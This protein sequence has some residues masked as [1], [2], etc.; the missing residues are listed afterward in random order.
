M[1]DQV[2]PRRGGGERRTCRPKA[3]AWPKGCCDS[4]TVEAAGWR[5]A[6][7][8]S[9]HTDHWDREQNPTPGHAHADVAQSAERLLPKQKVASSTLVIRFLFLT[10]ASFLLF[11][12]QGCQTN[13][14]DTMHQRAKEQITEQIGEFE[15]VDTITMLHEGRECDSKGWLVSTSAGQLKL[16][17]TTHGHAYVADTRELRDQIETNLAIVADQK[18]VLAKLEADNV[19]QGT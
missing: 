7:A 11:E 10:H 9:F 3:Y 16:I 19:R 18:S 6:A 2:P 1:P 5:T 13:E 4:R 17:L 8:E 12:T 15:I 14:R